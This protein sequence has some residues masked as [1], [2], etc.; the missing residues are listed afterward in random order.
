MKFLKGGGCSNQKTLCRGGVWIFFEVAL[1]IIIIHYLLHQKIALG[2]K[3][4]IQKNSKKYPSRSF[5]HPRRCLL[6]VSFIGMQHKLTWMQSDNTLALRNKLRSMVLFSI[7]LFPHNFPI[8]G[9]D[10]ACA[11]L[12]CSVAANKSNNGCRRLSHLKKYVHLASKL[13]QARKHGNCVQCP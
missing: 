4:L 12:L 11:V 8:I 10:D 7:A 5:A 6:A 3:W 13:G 2:H 9:S 1:I